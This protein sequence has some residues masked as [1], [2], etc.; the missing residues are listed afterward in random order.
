MQ[1]TPTNPEDL[2]VFDQL[3]LRDLVPVVTGPAVDE[4]MTGT[5]V[6]VGKIDIVLLKQYVIVDF[7]EEGDRIH[8]VVDHE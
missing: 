6:S 8:H 5:A 3:P 2:F 4:P 7:A 1:A